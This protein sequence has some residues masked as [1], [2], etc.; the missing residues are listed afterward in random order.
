MTEFNPVPNKIDD[1][2]INLDSTTINL[3]YT[4]P[5]QSYNVFTRN[6]YEVRGNELP[7]NDNNSG[8]SN[9]IYGEDQYTENT[10][11]A[12]NAPISYSRRTS[13]ENIAEQQSRTTQTS[14]T[15]RPK[16][17]REVSTNEG[18][19]QASTVIIGDSTIKYNDRKCC[20]GE[21]RKMVR[22][23]EGPQ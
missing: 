23:L 13:K 5:E 11:V 1:I 20:F 12:D 22:S 19:T 2:S 21:L 4:T 3:D 7:N 18:N 16:T 15:M 9:S 6:R 8:M 14:K 17:S 10:I